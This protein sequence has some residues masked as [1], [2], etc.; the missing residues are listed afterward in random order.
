MIGISQIWDPSQAVKAKEFLLESSLI[1]EVNV[2][3]SPLFPSG[4]RMFD[5]KLEIWASTESL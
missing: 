3:V 2:S 5:K 1:K 4:T